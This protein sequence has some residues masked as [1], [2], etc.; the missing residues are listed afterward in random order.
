MRKSGWTPSIVPNG[1]DQNVYIVLDDFGS[2]GRAYRE[3]DADRA[4]LEATIVD[5][6][7]GQY[8]NPVRASSPLTPPKNGHRTSQ[9]TV[10]MSCAGAAICNCATCH[11][12]SRSSLS[13]T[14][15]GTTISSFRSQC[16]CSD[17]GLPA[18][19]ARGH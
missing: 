12:T 19:E 17:N 14:K 9:A 10:R 6:L 2:N 13:G 18:Q 8:H 1:D 11:S 4:D 16:A 7:D 15:A 5:M 3:T